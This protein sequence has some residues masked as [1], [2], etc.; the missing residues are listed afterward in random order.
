MFNLSQYCVAKSDHFIEGVLKL[1]DLAVEGGE[2]FAGG[3]HTY[4]EWARASAREGPIDQTH[5]EAPALEAAG[6]DRRTG[7]R[8]CRR[9]AD[10]SAVIS[11]LTT[12]LRQLGERLS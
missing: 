1:L 4:L 10:L 5:K 12:E 9:R 8:R 3:G 6:A 11:A 2:V 7:V